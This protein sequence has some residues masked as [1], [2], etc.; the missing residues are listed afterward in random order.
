[1]TAPI[2]KHVSP[3]RPASFEEL[4]DPVDAWRMDE[5]ERLA[6]LDSV[7]SALGRTDYPEN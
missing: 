4:D 6:D 1:M 3:E 5:L 7:R 2:A